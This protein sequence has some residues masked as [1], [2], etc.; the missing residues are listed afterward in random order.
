[1][2]HFVA[3]FRD[4]NDSFITFG[5]IEYDKKSFQIYKLSQ[6]SW[7]KKVKEGAMHK[8]L[9]DIKTYSFF[10]FPLLCIKYDGIHD[11]YYLFNKF[12]VFKHENDRHFW[13]DWE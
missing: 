11:I 7:Q 1:M 2:T 4:L 13:N 12:V 3:K 8:D 9:I 5:S 10:Y 6:Y